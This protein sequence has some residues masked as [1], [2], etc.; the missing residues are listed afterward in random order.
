[1]VQIFYVISSIG[2][3][4][5]LVAVA[6]GASLAWFLDRH[7]R[8]RERRLFS[9]RKVLQTAIIDALIQLRQQNDPTAAAARLQAGLEQDKAEFLK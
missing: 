9:A 5:G 2:A 8:S 1:M 3:A 7:G 4:V 6:A